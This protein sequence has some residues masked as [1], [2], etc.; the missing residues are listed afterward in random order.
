MPIGDCHIKKKSVHGQ[1]A[2]TAK[3][4]KIIQL[5]SQ[6]NHHRLIFC[7]KSMEGEKVSLYFSLSVIQIFNFMDFL[8]SV[9]KMLDYD[10]EK[11]AG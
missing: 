4:G 9:D 10:I 2:C 7:K 5:V 6:C 3:F 1:V 11:P 8:K